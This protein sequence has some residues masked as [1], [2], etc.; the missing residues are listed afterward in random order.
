MALAC[1]D[2][3][4]AAITISRGKPIRVIGPAEDD[5]FLLIEMDGERFQAFETDLKG[6]CSAH[7][8]SGPA[9]GGLSANA[10]L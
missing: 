7:A 9:D 6:R 2:D 3:H 10:S 8:G 5:R 1:R 4:H